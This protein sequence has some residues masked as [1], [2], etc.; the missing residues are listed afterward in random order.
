[1]GRMTL[2]SR[3]LRPF[4]PSNRDLFPALRRPLW[5]SILLVAVVS[6][7][8][9]FD[10][11]RDPADSHWPPRV[12]AQEKD[13]DA[14]KKD[15]S[16]PGASDA[17]IYPV[18]GIIDS[19]RAKEIEDEIR[20]LVEEHGYR[21]I[22]LKLDFLSADPEPCIA[23]SEYVNSLRDQGV[24]AIAY[25]PNSGSVGPGGLSLAFAC[26]DVQMG[27]RSRLGTTREVD[28]SEF[29]VLIATLRRY[30][31]DHGYPPDLLE[32]FVNA[33]PALFRLKRRTRTGSTYTEYVFEY[34]P[35]D[36]SSF[37]KQ[38]ETIKKKGELLSVDE[39][40]ARDY[41]LIDRVFPTDSELL[42]HYKFFKSVHRLDELR[43]GGRIFRAS[44]G[45]FVRF[46]THPITRFFLIFVG[47]IGFVVELKMPG[48]GI[49]GVAGAL[50]FTLFFVGAYLGGT[51]TGFEI[52]LFVASL[53]LLA[54]EV[55]LIPGFGIAGLSGVALLL[56]SLILALH[57]PEA[58][59]EGV[60]WW[61][62][63]KTQITIVL[64]A[65]AASLIAT[66][67]ILNYMPSRAGSSGFALT[68]VLDEG[69]TPD[70]VDHE[71]R[72]TDSPLVTRRGVAVTALRPAGKVEIEGVLHDVVAVG[73]FLPAGTP[74]EVAEVEGARIVVR[75][76]GEGSAPA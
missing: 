60:S 15:D 74:I 23:L 29:R 56:G 35:A 24:T 76:T 61:D 8:P 21:N 67:V 5:A 58:V 46:L 7:L 18:K 9:G 72:A 3:G 38:P 55:F 2:K 65:I 42:L 33:E 40:G 32:S 53:L 22:I 59:P 64:F 43:S 6:A 57:A 75:P 19:G 14:E 68:T 17:V 4:Q 25:V 41:G 11:R 63:V 34:D 62:Q 31:E 16:A 49:P 39:R 36:T 13:T 48:F 30:A 28:A 12:E 1:M 47:V 69:S 54:A 52:G 26:D 71:G 50:G 27:E 70:P 10:D 73:E 44:D 51:T 66:M 20:V 37:V 45:F